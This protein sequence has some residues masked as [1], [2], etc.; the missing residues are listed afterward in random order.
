M[1][2][3]FCA[4]A[5]IST[6]TL[7]LHH[8]LEKLEATWPQFPHG[9]KYFAIKSKLQYP[10]P[11]AAHAPNQLHVHSVLQRMMEDMTTIPQGPKHPLPPP[12][13]AD[14]MLK[15]EYIIV[16]MVYVVADS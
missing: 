13:N 11:V 4:W 16:R 9:R 3:T 12:K 14:N 1:Q 5:Y 8:K 7:S 15:V 6:A 10:G 2:I